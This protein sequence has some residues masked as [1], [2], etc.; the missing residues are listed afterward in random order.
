MSDKLR[1]ILIGLYAWIAAV[2]FGGVLLDILYAKFLMGILGISESTMVFSEVSDTLLFIG[3]IL[4]I[5]AIAAIAVSWKFWV[6][7]NLFIASLLVF[8]FEFFIPI[9][10]SV[11]KTTQDLSW[12]RLLINGVA[13]L[14]ALAGLHQYYRKNR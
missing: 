1:A 14:L 12:L 6:A 4:V 7:R 2:F 10:F 8:S 13:S 9:F 11:V 3:F 5:S